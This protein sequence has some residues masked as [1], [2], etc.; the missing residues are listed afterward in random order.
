MARRRRA[1]RELATSVG[2]LERG[3]LMGLVASLGMDRRM[4]AR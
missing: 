1:Q 4:E 3:D 2:D